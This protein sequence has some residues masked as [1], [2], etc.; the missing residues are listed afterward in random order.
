MALLKASSK[1]G[2]AAQASSGV[3]VL[4]DLVCSSYFFKISCS[5]LL[6]CIVNDPINERKSIRYHSGSLQ[7]SSK[8]LGSPAC[9]KDSPNK[10]GI[11]SEE[12]ERERLVK[13]IKGADIGAPAYSCAS[14]D[15]CTGG[16]GGH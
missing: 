12:V 7:F 4:P 10:R 3:R 14:D 15:I 6:S 1:L 11:K 8:K 9:D 13:R 16:G 5:S 2:L